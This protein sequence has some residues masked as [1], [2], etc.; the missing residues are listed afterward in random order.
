MCPNK[1]IKIFLIGEFIPFATVANDT[2]DAPWAA[3][4]PKNIRKIWN[5]VYGIMGKTDSW[6]N[7]KLKISCHCP[8][9]YTIAIQTK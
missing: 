8:F 2:G 3:N 1:I 6:K 5:G 9:N 4:I 7:L